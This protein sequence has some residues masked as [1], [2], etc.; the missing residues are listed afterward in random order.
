MKRFSLSAQVCLA[1]LLLAAVPCIAGSGE[2]SPLPVTVSERQVSVT[3]AHP[4]GK[5]LIVGYERYWSNYSLKF[6]RHRAYLSADGTGTV[7]ITPAAGIRPDSVWVA[8]DVESGR[9]GVTAPAKAPIRQ[10][11]Q[12]AHALKKGSG[13]L[14]TELPLAYFVVVR[15]GEGAWELFAGDGGRQD[16]DG[17]ADGK[18]EL[19]VTDFKPVAGGGAGPESFRKGDLLLAF[20]PEQLSF[21]PVR[22]GE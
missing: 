14:V 6:H 11:L 7:K 12:A 13:R 20:S 3:G 10:T 17:R 15:P 19:S 8:V 1:L 5:V 9:Y 22:V 18:T 4:N 16:A 21:S 2:A